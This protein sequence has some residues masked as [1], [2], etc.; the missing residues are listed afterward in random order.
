MR[1]KICL[2]CVRYK[3]I[4]LE[5]DESESDESRREDTKCRESPCSRMTASEWRQK[6]STDDTCRAATTWR[7]SSRTRTRSR[8]L[9]DLLKN[10]YRQKPSNDPPHVHKKNFKF[11]PE[12]STEIICC[13]M[14]GLS[15]QTWL[16]AW[17]REGS[18]LQMGF[19]Q[20]L[21][22]VPT[23]NL[24]TRFLERLLEQDFYFSKQLTLPL[25]HP[26]SIHP[27]RIQ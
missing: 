16:W 2:N 9:R 22:F 14:S 18:Q 23:L 20:W 15:M 8:P 13:K 11:I 27:T 3:G 26:D 24:V 25:L 4:F 19:P 10:T 17:P 12:V 7:H 21:E 6:R 1:S 5:A